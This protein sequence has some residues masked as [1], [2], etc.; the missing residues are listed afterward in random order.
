MTAFG[1]KDVVK[2]VS[3]TLKQYPF[4]LTAKQ[5]YYC[6]VAHGLQND[7]G[8]Q[9]SFITLMSRARELGDIDG[10]K[11]VDRSRL[12]F[13]GDP[14]WSTGEG[15]LQYKLQEL[16]DSKDNATLSFWDGQPEYIEVWI[17]KDALAI[18]TSYI[19]NKYRVTLCTAKIVA[20]DFYRAAVAR[21]KASAD[22]GRQLSIIHLTDHDPD[23]LVAS[24]NLAERIGKNLTDNLKVNLSRVDLTY[25]TVT[26]YNLQHDP[27]RTKV[28]DLIYEQ[29]FGN[30]C[31]ELES[32]NPG[33]YIKMVESHIISHINTD[34]WE[35]R[36]EKIK[37]EREMMET[38]IDAL[39]AKIF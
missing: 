25:E 20:A 36:Q 6:A 23:G 17:D 8:I 4:K 1:Y 15:Y 3:D 39:F 38:L 9:R 10:T 2:L 37:R 19:T 29:Q 18:P 7:P 34:I 11:I 30:K 31:W 27:T 32:I 22:A 21:F 16:L 24:K 26:T 33:E 13:G 14:Q 12:Q 28:K 5:I 35:Q